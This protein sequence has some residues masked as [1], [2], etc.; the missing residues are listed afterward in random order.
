MFWAL[1]SPLPSCNPRCR[2]RL[3]WLAASDAPAAAENNRAARAG[4]L[5]FL[6]SAGT[7]GVGTVV[8]DYGLP[9]AEEG[10]VSGQAGAA[11]EEVDADAGTV[12]LR[13]P[14]GMTASDR[15]TVEGFR[16]DMTASETRSVVANLSVSGGSGFFIRPENVS[17]AVIS[18]ILPGL[19]VDP[20]SDVV[21]SIPKNSVTSEPEELTL[22]IREGFPT[23]FSGD[24]EYFNQNA[25]TRLQIRIGDLPPGASV[26][27]PE[28][29]TSPTSDAIFTV[30][31]G[32]E[33]TLPT[34]DGERSISI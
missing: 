18:D 23:A 24:T 33:T 26:T 11:I 29:T 19:K 9:I 16:F 34:E 31:S 32:S 20:K 14:A 5:V 4:D 10:R 2:R 7:T 12:S 21:F 6:V 1:L 17:V 22:T 30:L 13:I 27:F 3:F 25:A 15:V 28:S 8:I